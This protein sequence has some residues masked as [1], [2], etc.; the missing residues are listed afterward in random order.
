MA[1]CRAKALFI[2]WGNSSQRRVLSSR[3]VNRKVIVPV[4]QSCDSILTFPQRSTDSLKHELSILLDRTISRPT[5][6]TNFNKGVIFRA[7]YRYKAEVST[8]FSSVE[9]LTERSIFAIYKGVPPLRGPVV[10]GEIQSAKVHYSFL[11]NSE[12]YVNY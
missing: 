5:F 7:S 6:R 3:S 4:G 11:A 1:S 8:T 12:N 9:C 10:P 2:V